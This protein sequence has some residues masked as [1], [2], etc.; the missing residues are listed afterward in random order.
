MEKLKLCAEP[1]EV[2][3]S[4]PNVSYSV[5]V[6]NR[7][8]T[9][10]SIVPSLRAFRKRMLCGLQGLNIFVFLTTQLGSWAEFCYSVFSIVDEY[11]FLFDRINLRSSTATIVGFYL[12]FC[13]YDHER[14]S[15]FSKRRHPADVV[16]IQRVWMTTYGVSLAV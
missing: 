12:I 13:G 15:S 9:L 1:P 8:H 16:D 14:R 4:A 10:F 5:Y 7:L 2:A 6:K 11:N 3:W